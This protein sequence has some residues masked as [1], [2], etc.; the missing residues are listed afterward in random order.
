MSL[1]E[2]RLL[3]TVVI[4]SFVDSM[5]GD[6][7]TLGHLA[8]S[9]HQEVIEEATAA[10]KATPVPH[11]PGVFCVME[12]QEIGM[13]GTYSGLV[14]RPMGIATTSEHLLWVKALC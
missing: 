13:A 10:I 3:R 5:G 4:F 7:T 11:S 8:F 1:T 2:D 12:E 9:C 6:G 14:T